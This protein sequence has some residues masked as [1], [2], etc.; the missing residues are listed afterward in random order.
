MFIDWR[1][2]VNRML[3]RNRIT[4]AV[5]GVE[6]VLGAS[7][8]RA[9]VSDASTT[10]ADIAALK[11][12][13]SGLQ[14]KVDKLEVEEEKK[15][16]AETQAAVVK[17]AA[18]HDQADALS[19][20]WDPNVGFVLRSGD[21]QFSLHPGLTLAF[22]DMTSYRLSTPK[23]D[24]DL[25]THKGYDTQNGFDA[26]RVRLI[27]DGNYTKNF[28]YYFQFQ[29][30]QGTT[31]GLYDAYGAWHFGSSPLALKFGQ[32]KDPFSHERLI[33]DTAQMAVDRSLLETFFGGGNQSRV[34]GLSLMYDQDRLRAQV[35]IHDGYNTINTKFFDSSSSST[36]G[37]AMAGLAPADFGVSGRAE[38]L[39][40]GDRSKEY[41]PFKTYDGGF[42]ALGAKQDFL[43]VG[44]ALDMT[45]AGRAT[46]IEQTID[47]QLDLASGWSFYGAYMGSERRLQTPQAAVASAPLTNIVVTPGN[48]YDSGFM[49]Q[50]GYLLTPNIE[51]FA[52]YDYTLLDAG[53]IAGNLKN[54]AQEVT[55]GVN[56]YI[57]KQHLK[58][59]VDASWLPDGAPVDQDALGILADSGHAE[60]VLRVQFQLSI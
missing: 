57:D 34:Q 47:A 17:D 53:S 6:L 49:V 46:G 3:K 7:L 15:Q 54:D 26:T 40:L 38:Y 51:P 56:Y 37:L 50:A 4:A 39:V 31:F 11:Q 23:A 28:N 12:E 2:K 22:R 41:N 25:P 58:F 36:P 30:D 9:Q 8:A 48:Y 24:A 35:A 33:S 5:L 45:Q 43:V 32:F 59:T 1:R 60:Y 20:G 27:L 13:I 52:R 10:N 16:L 19:S 21:G 55:A 29:D 18:E 14:A 44:A 42:T